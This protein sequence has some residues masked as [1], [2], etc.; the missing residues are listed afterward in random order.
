MMV[1]MLPLIM[2]VPKMILFQYHME[3]RVVVELAQ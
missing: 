2:K 1:V 3:L